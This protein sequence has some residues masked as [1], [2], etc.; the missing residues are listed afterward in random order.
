[1]QVKNSNLYKGCC[2]SACWYFLVNSII[3]LIM[4]WLWSVVSLLD[5][6]CTMLQYNNLYTFVWIRIW[7]MFVN[8]YQDRRALMCGL[9]YYEIIHDMCSDSVSS[10]GRKLLPKDSIT[11]VIFIL[12]STLLTHDVKEET[13]YVWRC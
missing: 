12:V 10:G 13:K 7:I 4:I 11:D 3:L 8:A 1:M 9:K 5:W 2:V 6:I